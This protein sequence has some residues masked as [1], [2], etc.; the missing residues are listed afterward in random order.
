M[1]DEMEFNQGK[2]FRDSSPVADTSNKPANGGVLGEAMRL[3]GLG[4]KVLP[5]N[6]GE[7]TPATPHGCKDATCKTED[8]LEMF[9]RLPGAN[10]AIATEGLLALDVDG[11]DNP[12]LQTRHEGLDKARCQITPSGGRHLLFRQRS[13]LPMGNS[14]SRVAP[15][16]DTRGD[17]G[18]IVVAPSR[19]A[20]GEYRWARP[21]DCRPEALPGVPDWLIE[22]CQKKSEGPPAVTEQHRLGPVTP[23][24]VE[25]ARRYMAAI[26]PAISGQRGHDKTFDAACSLVLGFNL[27]P[28][29][30]FPILAEWNQKCQPP[31]TE[32]ELRHKLKDAN[33]KPGE[34]GDLLRESAELIATKSAREQQGDQPAAI[35]AP[36]QQRRF[37]M[38]VMTC[39][40]LATGSF[41]AEYYIDG[42][43]AVG[44]PMIVAGAQKVLKTS[45]VADLLISVAMATPFLEHYPVRRA[46][47][48]LF[49]TGE[50]GMAAIRETLARIC[51]AR[52]LRLDQVSGLF[53]SE[54]LPR[55]DRPD[56]IAE[57]QRQL[58]DHEIKLVAIDPAYLAMPG[59]RAENFFVQGERLR[60]VAAACQRG[61]ATL[62]LVH[63]ISKGRASYDPPELADMAWS[64]FSEFARQW[65]LIGRRA[66]YVPGTGEHELWLSAGGSLGHNSHAAVDIVEGL[67]SDSGGRRWE[68]TVSSAGEKREEQRREKAAA[69]AE[70]LAMRDAEDRR[71]ML[72][73]VRQF[74]HGETKNVLRERAG[75]RSPRDADTLRDL[76]GEGRVESFQG[77]KHGRNETFYRAT[78]K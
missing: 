10:V 46:A 28:D 63:H 38:H 9:R 5:I 75:L 58:T 50:S 31:W 64:G 24:V 54:N 4:Y 47:R 44:Q 8:V 74:P 25:R 56:Q 2:D 1:L 60:E 62:I 22:A 41:D 26:P 55:F 45:I 20:D 76:I 6:P 7:K 73:S 68:V 39:A 72:E 48:C 37:E 30:A 61:G 42:I 14:V 21:L 17:G 70:Q 69:K 15:K 52:G 11:T 3:A 19:T 13:G 16:V 71:K 35:A 77:T 66:K 29:E 32:R 57:L 49:V 12:F 59:D 65:L 27:S 78:G 34:R 36:A 18:Y 51:S 53:I 67:Q 23:D 43:L 33:E 40:Q